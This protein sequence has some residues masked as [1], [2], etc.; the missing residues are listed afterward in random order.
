MI[1]FITPVELKIHY[2]CT[3]E[4]NFVGF[5]SITTKFFYIWYKTPKITRSLV[6]PAD[7]YPLRLRAECLDAALE[8][9]EGFINVIVCD[10]TVEIVRVSSV[11][12]LGLF[13]CP[14]KI[15]VLEDKV[16]SN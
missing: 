4:C 2:A 5:Q 10:C 7:R 9:S 15:F 1:Y 3:Y 8:F 16:T 6:D 13:N 14:L 11:K 12:L